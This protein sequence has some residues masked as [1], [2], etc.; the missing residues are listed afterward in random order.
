MFTISI[1]KLLIFQKFLSELI[2]KKKSTVQKEKKTV[3]RQI[4]T[5]HNIKFFTNLKSI[6]LFNHLHNFIA[7][8]VRRRYGPTQP[9]KRPFNRTPKKFGQDRKLCAQD[10]FLIM[11]MKLRLGLLNKDLAQRFNVSPGLISKHFPLMA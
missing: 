3:Y 11:L 7:P 9:V 8:L 6:E 5:R 2:N 1:L 10:E 4:L